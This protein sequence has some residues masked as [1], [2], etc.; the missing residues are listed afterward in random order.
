[1][2]L[3]SEIRNPEKTYSQSG[4]QGPLLLSSKKYGVEIRDTENS[5]P[6]SG[7]ATLDCKLQAYETFVPVLLYW[8]RERTGRLRWQLGWATT[9][10]RG[11]TI[12]MDSAM[13]HFT[14]LL[15]TVS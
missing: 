12:G 2:G 11:N 3:D 10:L 15:F 14:I 7:S 6:G 13:E 4:I 5:H 1:M 9:S 8:Q